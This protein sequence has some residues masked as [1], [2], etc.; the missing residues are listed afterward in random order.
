M[1][2]TN[3]S[4]FTKSLR[5][6]A[7]VPRQIKLGEVFG[8][9]KVLPPMR[10]AGRPAAL[11]VV[12]VAAVFGAVGGHSGASAASPSRAGWWKVGLPVADVGIGGLGNL[13][14]PQS[15]D[16]PD[17][18]LLVQGGA[19]AGQPAAYAALAFDLA[20]AVIAGPLRLI[21]A[22]NTVSVPGSKLI[23]CPLVNDSF[24]PADGGSVTEGP[25]Y[26]CASAVNATVDASGAYVFDLA[27]LRRGAGLSVAILPTAPTDRV[28][29]AKPGD[30]ALAVNESSSAPDVPAPSP[31]PDVSSG[32]DVAAPLPSDIG[33][34]VTVSPAL[35]S[36]GD[37]AAPAASASGSTAAALPAAQPA[38]ATHSSSSS[39]APY[40]V[41]ALLGLAAVLWIGAGAGAGAG[42]QP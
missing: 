12:V 29:F 28:V 18:G 37:S 35:P 5:S 22:P 30:S 24:A 40:V 16:V 8:A 31:A 14:D 39:W 2:P 42:E 7:F 41:V 9:V 13:H 6:S 38:T 10:R 34:G 17:G 36:V 1:T 20:N 21:L 23:A 33:G 27:G 26:S 19:S 11:V 4:K 32:G 3:L 15:A 25:S